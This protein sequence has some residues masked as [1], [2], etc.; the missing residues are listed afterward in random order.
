MVTESARKDP[1]TAALRALPVGEQTALTRELGARAAALGLTYL[2]GEGFRPIP[3]ALPP[4]VFGAELL[5]GRAA[6]ARAMVAGV[7]RIA[8]AV[9]AGHLGMARRERILGELGPTERALVERTLGAVSR[10][11]TV[12][13]DMFAAGAGD[14]VLEVN[15]TIPAMQGYSDIAAEAFFAAMLAR[16]APPRTAS[17]TAELAAL[18]GVAVHRPG[19][20]RSGFSARRADLSRGAISRRRARCAHRARRGPV[21]RRRGSLRRARGRQ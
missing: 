5:R 9:L 12:R 17:A 3:V 8:A 7:A 20:P 2:G 16:F 15:A 13:V 4:V 6:L 1:L 11:A 10:L 21:A 19:A 18:R 14:R